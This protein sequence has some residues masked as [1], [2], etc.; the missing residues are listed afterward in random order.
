MIINKNIDD[1]VNQVNSGNVICFKTDTIWGFSAKSTDYK[2]ITNLY[3]IKNRN[4]DKPFIFLIKKD[5]DLRAL[6]ENLNETQKKLIDAFWPGPLT[7]I[8]NAKQNLDIL[9]HYKDNK[10]IAL[11][12]P[13]DELCQNILSKLDYPLPSTSVNHEGQKPLNNFDEIVKN[14][15]NENFAILQQDSS[16]NNKE[17]SSTIVKVVDNKIQILREGEI[18]KDVKKAIDDSTKVASQIKANDEKARAKQLRRDN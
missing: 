16:L 9:K 12:M 3:K 1:L 7:I 6:V 10:T 13:E 8:F 5:Q 18:K 4:P 11:R 2:A 17:I 14:F 15:K